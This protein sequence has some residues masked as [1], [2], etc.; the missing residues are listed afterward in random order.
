MLY[1]VNNSNMNKFIE[2]INENVNENNEKYYR[3]TMFCDRA[4]KPLVK[5][6]ICTER[7]WLTFYQFVISSEYIKSN[8]DIISETYI[9]KGTFEKLNQILI[10]REEYHYEEL[11]IM[12]LSHST[13]HSNRL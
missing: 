2:I 4:P 1:E 10:L 12:D 11:R 6:L 13:N 3:L 9:D 5:I 8:I 7:E